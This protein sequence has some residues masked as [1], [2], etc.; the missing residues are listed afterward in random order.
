MTADQP[1][2]AAGRF[3]GPMSRRER[4]MRA[5]QRSAEAA[6][7]TTPPPEPPEPPAPAS[8]RWSPQAQRERDRTIARFK[9]AGLPS[10]FM[11]DNAS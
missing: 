1:R 2:D 4:A 8:A 9:A 11:E 5:F 6:G 10:P 7:A 3:T